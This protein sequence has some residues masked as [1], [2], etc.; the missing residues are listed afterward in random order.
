MK[1]IDAALTG[2]R[3]LEIPVFYKHTEESPKQIN[4]TGLKQEKLNASSTPTVSII[5][6]LRNISNPANPIILS[7][8]ILTMNIILNLPKKLF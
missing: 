3:N 5:P 7:I 1:F 4:P 6:L 2:L 8:L